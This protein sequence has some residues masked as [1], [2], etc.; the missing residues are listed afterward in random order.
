[1]KDYTKLCWAALGPGLLLPHLLRA[2][3]PAARPNLLVVM[4]DQFRGDALGF[5]GR[6]AVLTPCLDAFAREAVVVT[7]AVSGYPV[8][9]PARGMFLTGAYPHRNGVLTNCQSE[10]AAQDVELREEIVC[11]SDVLKAEGYRTAYIGKWHLD[12]PV[13][14]YVDCYNNRGRLAWNEWC[15]PGRRHGF[16]YWVSYGTYDQHLR[17]MYWDTD[18]GRQ[19]FYY[20]D[21]W[22]P[23]YEADLAI[24]YIEEARESD[25]PFAMMVSMNPPHTG[26]ELVPDR[27][28]ERYRALDV[29]SVVAGMPH[30]RDAGPEYVGMFR[31]SLA[32]YYACITGVDEQFGRIVDALKR[33]GLFDDTIV[34]FVSDHGDSMGMHGNIG[35]NIFYEEAVRVPFLISWGG[36]LTPRRDDS[37]LL[38]LEDFCP[39]VLSLMGLERKIP[40]TVQTRDLSRQLRGSRTEMPRYQLYMRYDT[41]DE[42]GKHPDTGMRGIRDGRYTYAVRF[43]EGTVV[44][45]YLFDRL[46]DPYQTANLAGARTALAARLRRAMVRMLE[47]AGDP[48][49]PVFARR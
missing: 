4:A 31:R 10:S 27:Y 2:A 15:P 14:P 7:Q 43:E 36:G 38:S 35:K 11:W 20:V 48:A 39:T 21:R 9:S 33:C 8:S 6:E 26:Y 18:G 37:L 44:A 3:T 5:M 12:K 41:V 40:A 32:D 29:D 34:V 16:D 30:L 22:G 49:A 24:R 28:K 42:T 1:M 46:R 19:D 17:P 25:R 45:E 23:E 13:K 47:E